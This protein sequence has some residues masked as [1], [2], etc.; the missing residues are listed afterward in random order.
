[1][2]EL[3]VRV[4]TGSRDVPKDNQKAVQLFQFSETNA[5][6]PEDHQHVLYYQLLLRKFKIHQE[7][8]IHGKLLSTQFIILVGIPMSKE[9]EKEMIEINMMLNQLA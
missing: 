7:T 1:L 6:T 9:Q 3:A 5:K 8:I 4:F 2:S